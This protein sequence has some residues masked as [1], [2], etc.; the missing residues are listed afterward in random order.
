MIALF[1]TNK[2][3]SQLI[4]ESGLSQ[5]EFARLIGTTPA[6][7]SKWVNG[8]Q[9]PSIDSLKT[10]CEKFYVPFSYFQESHE[11]QNEIVLTFNDL[12]MIEAVNR[13]ITVFKYSIQQ[14]L[15]DESESQFSIVDE[16]GTVIRQLSFGELSPILY[17]ITQTVND[18]L[19]YHPRMNYLKI[20]DLK[21]F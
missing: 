15:P 14:N 6:V 18:K 12:A 3:I 8:K 10:I 13:F 5:K 2:K 17:E 21:P 7:V 19:F 11:S 20:K 1:Y 16:N 9:N 4:Q